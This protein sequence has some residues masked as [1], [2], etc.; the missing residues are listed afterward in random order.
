MSD[1]AKPI[2]QDGVSEEID[3]EELSDEEIALDSIKDYLG[4]NSK[5]DFDKM[6]AEAVT[7]KAEDYPELAAAFPEMFPG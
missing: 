5:I 3:D 6:R 2:F 1:E 7:L 4:E